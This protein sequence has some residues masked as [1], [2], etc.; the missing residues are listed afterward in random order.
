MEQNLAIQGLSN[1]MHW[2]MI[3]HID[4]EKMSDNERGYSG[5]ELVRKRLIFDNGE[6]KTV[7]LKLAD[8]KERFA[9]VRLSNQHQ[10]SPV[11][12]TCDTFSNAPKW[13]AMEDLGQRQFPKINN[14]IWLGKV[15]RCLAK[16]HIDNMGKKSEMPWLPVADKEYWKSVV[17]ELSLTHVEKEMKQNSTFADRFGKY[18][19]ALQENAKKFVRNMTVLCEESNCMTLTHGDLQTPQGSHIYSYHEE[20]RI[21]D[22]GFCRYAPFYIDLAGWFNGHN[23]MLYY[24]ELQRQGLE[25]SY[26]DFEECANISAQ[27]NGFIYLYP[28][29]MEYKRGNPDKFLQSLAIILS[30]KV[31]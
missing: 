26:D 1:L 19:P 24:S 25:L 7:I 27:Y 9:M 2:G 28:S 12:F 6:S 22:F 23:L 21:I 14:D 11:S 3:K 31:I 8:L 10:C 29:L 17:T 30:K 18:L 20:P 13:L 4:N 5:A 16:I 15:A